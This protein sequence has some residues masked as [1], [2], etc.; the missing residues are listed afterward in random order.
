MR[1]TRI[2]GVSLLLKQLEL[3]SPVTIKDKPVNSYGDEFLKPPA[4]KAMEAKYGKYAKYS[5]PS[6]CHVDTSSEVILN[7][8]PDGPRQGR[9]ENNYAL[10]EFTGSLWDEKFFRANILKKK[11]GV[12]EEDK[13]RVID[14]A[15]NSFLLGFGLLILRQ[16]VMPIWYVGQPPMSAVQSMNIEAD[17]GVL[18]LK[19]CKTI[20]WRGK[21]IY[22]YR[23]TPKQLSDMEKTPMNVLKHPET[24]EKRFPTSREHVVCIA[25]CTHLGCIPI[26][27]E[28]IFGGFFCPCHGSHYDISGRIRQGPAPLNLEVP[29]YKWLTDTTLYLGS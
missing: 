16:F 4:S 27:N 15:V 13:H 14:Y 10:K 25:I 28:G 19:Q 1:R 3:V 26:P 18:E 7:T 12:A 24:D 20:V 8:Y 21:P 22:V 2:V 11:A 9:I 6:L 23:R 29:P 5:D 17:V